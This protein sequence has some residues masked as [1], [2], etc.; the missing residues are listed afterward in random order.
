M[1][2]S[3]DLNR[4]Q[5]KLRYMFKRVHGRQEKTWSVV[6]EDMKDMEDMKYSKGSYEAL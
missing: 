6:R 4:T 1:C 2:N 3:E 5:V